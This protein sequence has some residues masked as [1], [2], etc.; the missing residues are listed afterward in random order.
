MG[1]KYQKNIR[2]VAVFVIA[3][4][5]FAANA[6]RA[7]AS[8]ENDRV[9]QLETIAWLKASDN[10]DGVFADYI[11]EQYS[12]YFSAQSRFVV[13]PLKGLR[14]VLDSSSSKYTDLVSQPEI[15][16]KVALR[17]KVENLIRTHVYKESSTYRFVL[18]WVYAPKGDVL[19]SVEFRYAD[20]GKEDGLINSD[21]PTAI[22]KALDEL[23]QKLPF[24]G[25]V[26]GV[27]GDT[28]TVSV[29]HAQGVTQNE[30][31]TIYTLQSVKRHPLLNTIEEWRWQPIGRAQVNQVD[32]SLSFAKITELEPGQKII[33]YQK[34]REI[35]PA[36]E[37]AIKAAAAKKKD[38]PRVGWVAA[39][40]G[41]GSYS[42]DVGLPGGTSGRTGGGLAESFQ[43]DSQ[44]WLNSRFIAQGTLGA[45]IFK[46]GPKD[47]ATDT[48]TGLSYSGSGNDFRLAVGYALYPMKTVY[49]TIGWV[50]L[51]FKTT[52]YSLPTALTDYSADSYFG[53]FFL[54]LGG[55]ITLEHELG[56]EMGL[57]LGL[58]RGA[59][60]GDLGFGDASASTDLSFHVSGI[61]HLDQQFFVRLLIRLNSQ[62]MDFAGG[63]SISEKSFSIS[64]SLMYYF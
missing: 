28:I 52:H 43:I 15:L 30:F 32:E 6:L 2:L 3:F 45:T 14:D 20:P 54:G 4:I 64:P 19:S 63:E 58:L 48:S 11:D 34:V 1:A 40:I 27:D 18:E 50:D 22:Q 10:A 29:G 23:I 7:Q 55:Q 57:D 36:P 60:T 35:L 44:V 49:D 9:Y 56:A 51:G 47:L 5:G 38:V 21:L 16:R 41:I 39:N 8:P 42:R 46:Y 24:L 31:V 33:R 53:S 13:K 26:T 17:F 12:R 25:Q 37:V 62:S 59:S 61:Y